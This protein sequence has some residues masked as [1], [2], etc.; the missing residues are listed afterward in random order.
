MHAI[1]SIW[2]TS[3]CDRAV[4]A[5]WRLKRQRTKFD[6]YIRRPLLIGLVYV[7]NLKPYVRDNFS[8]K[9]S[10]IHECYYVILKCMHFCAAYTNKGT[11]DEVIGQ[12][13]AFL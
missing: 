10:M 4:A 3:H 8:L 12:Y 6:W 9:Y 1:P 11:V 7:G 5:I 2:R 13:C